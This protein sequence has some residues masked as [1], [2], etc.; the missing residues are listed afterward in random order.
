MSCHG[1][2]AVVISVWHASGHSSQA[3][4]AGERQTVSQAEEA[5]ALSQQ[6]C[7]GKTKSGKP[8][9]SRQVGPDGY[10]HHHRP[11]GE[12]VDATESA[13]SQAKA[14]A[15]PHEL[16]ERMLKLIEKG[17]WDEVFSLGFL[18]TQALEKLLSGEG[19]HTFDETS[20]A[21]LRA[22]VRGLV[23]KINEE[24]QVT[25]VLEQMVVQRIVMSYTRLGLAEYESSTRV[26]PG[27][28]FEAREHFRKRL[29]AASS[30]FLRNLRALKDLKT[31]P[32]TLMIKDAGQVNV[33][34]QQVNVA[35][36][37]QVRKTKQPRGEIVDAERSEAKASD[38][39]QAEEDS[40]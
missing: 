29:A 15:K 37:D 18:Q 23:S 5:T 9:R 25:T 20:A 6:R 17:A 38:G 40:K 27:M 32:M 12:D 30:E 22:E 19:L 36:P 39:T 21:L 4:Q 26:V 16:Q 3:Q 34:Q 24:C 10:C 1:L 14:L 2:S 31:V 8:C 35:D 7:K 11:S 13:Q 33:G 28:T